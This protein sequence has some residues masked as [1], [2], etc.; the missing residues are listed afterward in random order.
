MNQTYQV[1]GL[2][3]GKTRSTTA[4]HPQHLK[5]EEDNQSNQKLS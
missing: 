4:A 3:L 5:V 1:L 2:N